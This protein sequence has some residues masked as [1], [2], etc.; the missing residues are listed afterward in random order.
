MKK[1]ISIISV[2]IVAL[3]LTVAIA[4]YV[5][6]T[7]EV[8]YTP[9]LQGVQIRNADVKE[10]GTPIK[11]GF[12]FTAVVDESVDFTDK[13]KV[14]DHGFF[15]AKGS[16]TY[17]N[18]TNAINNGEKTITEIEKD[19]PRTS[20]IVRASL[21][22]T[23][24]RFSVTLVGLEDEDAEVQKKNFMTEVTVVAFV[25]VKADN[26]NG[27][28]YIFNTNGE[29]RIRSVAQI[30]MNSLNGI[31]FDQKNFA[32][33][34]ADSVKEYYVRANV[35]NEVISVNR[36]I[37]DTNG[38][39]VD[40]V[41]SDNKFV[42]GNTVDAVL[43]VV[44]SI[45][46]ST[47]TYSDGTNSYAMGSSVKLGI[48]DY[49]LTFDGWNGIAIVAPGTNVSDTDILID[50]E[51]N[52]Y[53]GEMLCGTI[54]EALDIEGVKTVYVRE[55]NYNENIRIPHSDITLVGAN[56]NVP[57][58]EVRTG[59]TQFT[60]TITLGAGVDNIR[61]NGF[62]FSG[63]AQINHETIAANTTKTNEIN[64]DNFQLVNSSVNVNVTSGNG[65]INFNETSKNYNKN[66]L[67]DGCYFTGNTTTAMIYLDNNFGLKVTNTITENVSFKTS[68]NGAFVFVDDT[69]SGLAGSLYFNH[70]KISN[71]TNS[72]TGTA[73][74]I[75]VDWIGDYTINDNTD[76]I[77]ETLQISNNSFKNI[78][79]TVFN[80][81]N[82]NTVG[83]DYDL[84]EMNYNEFDN[85]GQAMFIR[86]GA[87]TYNRTFLFNHNKIIYGANF[88]YIARASYNGDSNAKNTIKLVDGTTNGIS[89]GDNTYVN[90]QPLSNYFWNAYDYSHIAQLETL[91]VSQ[92]LTPE[93]NTVE[94]NGYTYYL[95]IDAFTTLAEAL[96]LAGANT[97]IYVFPGTY[98]ENV[99]IFN[100]GTTLLGAYNGTN[101]TGARENGTVFTGTITINSGIKDVVVDGFDFSGGAQIKSTPTTVAYD[102]S[103]N[104]E[105]IQVL[106]SYVNVN[107]TEGKG[108]I[109]FA[110]SDKVYNKELVISGC[111]FTGTTTKAMIYC[112]NNFGLDFS[113]NVIENVTLTA[114]SDS[115]YAGFIFLN[116]TA[117][118]CAAGDL[119]VNN[120]E[121]TNINSNHVNGANA[122]WNNYVG[123]HNSGTVNNLQVNNNTFENIA[124]LCLNIADSD[125]DLKYDVAEMNSNTIT[126]CGK[127]LYAL[128]GLDTTYNGYLDFKFNIIN[129]YSGNSYI[130]KGAT[131][132]GAYGTV[133]TS[134]I[135]ASYNL[136][137]DEAGVALELVKPEVENDGTYV[138]N[139]PRFNVKVINY[140][141]IMTVTEVVVD[142]R[143]NE[144]NSF[145]EY[146]GKG[147]RLGFNAYST[148]TEAFNYINEGTTVYVMA[149]TY[150][151]DV[152]IQTNGTTIIGVDAERVNPEQ[153]DVVIT[154]VISL[155]NE[156]DDITF[157]NLTFL[158][159]AQIKGSVL[160]DV[161]DDAYYNHENIQLL[162]LY[163][164]VVITTGDGFLNLAGSNNVYSKDIVVDNSYFK[165]SIPRG[166]IFLENNVN[167]TVT[168]SYFTTEIGRA[169]YTVNTAQ[170]RGLA[171]SIDVLRNTFENIDNDCVSTEYVGT[172]P[173]L[174]AH[175]DIS[176]NTFR[177]IN[178]IAINSEKF[179]WA[180]QYD[181]IKF[182]YNVFEGLHKGIWFVANTK[183]VAEITYN[184]F[185][186][187]TGYTEEDKNGDGVVDDKDQQWTRYFA[188][189]GEGLRVVLDHNLYFLDGVLYTGTPDEE[190]ETIMQQFRE[191]FVINEHFVNE[192]TNTFESVEEYEAAVGNIGA[193]TITIDQETLQLNE[194]TQI[195]IN[196]SCDSVSY[197][198]S[199]EGIVE[200]DEN[201][202]VSALAGGKTTITVTV[203]NEFGTYTNSFDVTVFGTKYDY[204]VKSDL[205]DTV[206][207]EGYTYTLNDNAYTSI[208]A[209]MTVVSD[210][211]D[212][213]VFPGTY[214]QNFTISNNNISFY[215]EDFG[216]KATADRTNGTIITGKITLA[217]Y[218]HDITFDGINFIGTAEVANTPLAYSATYAFNNE[219]ISFQNC[220]I[221]TTT[222]R[223][224][225]DC[226]ANGS[227]YTKNV[228]FDRCYFTGS[229]GY[230]D[231]IIFIN[232]SYNLSVTNSIIEDIVAKN[233]TS[234]T[235]NSGFIFIEDAMR[236]ISGDLIFTNNYVDGLSGDN[237]NYSEIIYADYVGKYGTSTEAHS[238]IINENNFNNVNGFVFNC[239]KGNTTA[240]GKYPLE[241]ME[242]NYNEFH[243]VFKIAWVY[244]PTSLTDTF[245]F[246][247]NKIYKGGIYTYA[248]KCDGTTI[249][250]DASKN[251]YFDANGDVI[252]TGPV[253]S[254]Y[255]ASVFYE[256]EFFTSMNEF[257]DSTVG[258]NVELSKDTIELNE[259]STIT[260]TGQYTSVTYETSNEE[261]AVVTS[262]GVIHA[263][264][265][266]AATITVRIQTV[267]GEV[268]SEINITVTDKQE[269]DLL[270]DLLEEGNN[271]NALYQNIDYHYYASGYGSAAYLVKG[272]VNNYFPST[273]LS[274][275]IDPNY[276][277][278]LNYT[279]RNGNYYSLVDSNYNAANNPN[280]VDQYGGIRMENV[281]F[282]VI[283]DTESKTTAANTMA[284]TVGS[285][286]GGRFRSSYHYFIDD[287]VLYQLLDEKYVGYHAGEG[288]LYTDLMDTGITVE[289]LGKNLRYRPT[290]TVRNFNGVDYFYLDDVRTNITVDQRFSFYGKDTD[291]YIYWETDTDM[292]TASGTL[293][294][295]PNP[296]TSSSTA[297]NKLGLGVFIK[298]GKYVLPQYHFKRGNYNS[299]GMRG[300]ANS[301]GIET[302]VELGHDIYKTWQNTAKF[303]A[304]MLVRYN[305]TPDRVVFHNNFTNKLCP[306]T[307]MEAN[308]TDQFLDMV[309]YE[310]MVAQ[311]YSNY[312]ITFSST[313]GLIDSTGRITGTISGTTNI[314]YTI[315]VSDGTTTKSI[316]L[317][318]TVNA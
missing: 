197:S 178:G 93:N 288:T 3:F 77:A 29:H 42:L 8:N 287:K 14:L 56:V 102:D 307:M 297:I 57:A 101:A 263:V 155:A 27:Y 184:K 274:T 189:G 106:N 111:Y 195:N 169:I 95:G 63:S 242:M 94:Y 129:F 275:T 206:E 73:N 200:V 212:V 170:G 150:D 133:N 268:V 142:S 53:S 205:T 230:L 214:G 100:D 38:N 181:Y 46:Y 50:V 229:T 179:G 90:V 99:T 221:N 6:A 258:I 173:G 167:I 88:Q 116:D 33:L 280:N 123:H 202:V 254:D 279:I 136:Y 92:S 37:L 284:Y 317:V 76:G 224:F 249:S 238:I 10:D 283:H 225:F 59:G 19:N 290:V 61:I 316:D 318:A 139:D 259:T 308:Q 146:E 151:E 171:G 105:N 261:V 228:S 219:N 28:E 291:E 243:N 294:E 24:S 198:Y 237:S 176:Y 168:D 43:P 147:Y 187:T 35:T 134:T 127:A 286:G 140:D 86:I 141:D 144:E 271:T 85:C 306:H 158:G 137:Y 45:H 201:G 180:A 125:A 236:G 87:S 250:T 66:I 124:G 315:T 209:L 208:A 12:K 98:N 82:T 119:I 121:F 204:V 44:N 302:S 293:N 49:K 20:N 190:G 276:R 154:G 80:V 165:G 67:I 203:V 298:D 122:I 130:A 159:D 289:Q 210:D 267:N 166:M 220:Y 18:L 156:I 31:P 145:I 40:V 211:S 285:Q 30:A 264:N 217:Q 54:Q 107:I 270:L 72:S 115:A 246:N 91:V 60:G 157:D 223:G 103:V 62:E 1:I 69:S 143:L 222:G 231:G 2:F 71:L 132:N 193:P 34:I 162:N 17:D 164:D 188:K 262:D 160:S 183:T 64:N 58:T 48:G 163:V 248:V 112:D 240:A 191:D 70:N 272:A 277:I 273:M 148:L 47:L 51:G 117:N 296:L 110:E 194:Q 21:T 83:L 114:A 304:D 16:Y 5:N 109:E 68:S 175:I 9:T 120:N 300:G 196:G 282:I 104:N 269:I 11:Q 182:N 252:T 207:L 55:G 232:N 260:I 199:N 266:G 41:N 301:I 138:V 89:A 234:G 292:L 251:I 247:Y 113:H 152:T 108:F 215:G 15:I 84:M 227:D 65:F 52:Y 32:H 126:N 310:Y 305:L 23:G 81:T 149:G 172:L 253:E 213:Y 26:A 312:T 299:Y 153:P 79:G 241:A 36:E 74:G 7:D 13:E 25:K 233:G 192:I 128:M 303:V 39:V 4:G 131:S 161:H 244:V 186:I 265:A 309:Y 218:V 97:T 311:Y 135:D 281:E 255:N 216:V 75:F 295:T 78:P 239:E 235:Y 226:E 313:S 314:P 185:D 245:Y 22:G 174:V 177:N 118:G 256:E 257:L 278:N 96:G